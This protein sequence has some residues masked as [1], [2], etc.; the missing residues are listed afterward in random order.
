MESSSNIK[1]SV[2]ITAFNKKDFIEKSVNSVL[3]STYQNLEVIIVEDKSTDNTLEI[4]KTLAEKDSRIKLVIHEVNKGA[5]LSRR[6]G[7]KAS[8]GDFVSLIDGDDYISEDFYS[9]LVK[10]QIETDAD[11]VSGGITN[12]NPDGTKDIKLFGEKVSEGNQK[13]LDYGRGAIIF[14]NNKI[15][16]RSLYN[17]V[18]YSDKR[19]CEDTPVIIPLLYHANKVA[20]VDNAGYYYYHSADTL[21]GSVSVIRHNIACADC[22]V[23]LRNYFKCRD[24]GEFYLNALNFNQFLGYLYNARMANIKPEDLKD[25]L[26][27]FINS[28]NYLLD[29][30]ITK[31]VS[32]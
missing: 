32:K 13:L 11:I 18:E 22:M 19:Y 25:C 15:V 8:T 24:N 12:I 5:G 23:F 16:R 17:I 28:F 3:N 31:S 21:T 2:V 10:K 4:V 1:I 27:E 29:N 9:S 20:Y 30:I 7:I 14:L 26:P 6:D